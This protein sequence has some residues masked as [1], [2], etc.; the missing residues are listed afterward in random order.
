VTSC[1]EVADCAISVERAQW[2]MMETVTMLLGRSQFPA[3]LGA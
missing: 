3:L 2:R 1:S